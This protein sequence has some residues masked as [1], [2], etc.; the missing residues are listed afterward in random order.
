MDSGKQTRPRRRK[1]KLI[2]ESSHTHDVVQRYTRLVHEV[3]A[4]EK[5]GD[6]HI[7]AVN[8]LLR[9]QFGDFQGLSTPVLGQGLAFQKFDFLAGFA[10][11]GYYQILHTGADHWMTVKLVSDHE[12]EVYDSVF[13]RPNYITLKQISSIAQCKSSTIQ[14]NLNKVQVQRN[15]VDCGVYAIAYL[16]D[17]CHGKDPASCKYAGAVELRDHL[18]SCF[19]NGRM[20]PFPSSDIVK[21]KA[22]I[23]QFQVYCSCRLPRAIDHVK[24]PPPEEAVIMIQCHICDNLYHHSCVG[25]TKEKARRMNA[26]PRNM[27][28]CDYRGCEEAFGDV[29]ESD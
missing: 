17:L 22:L 12:A 11:F 21:E 6:D 20:S 5:L 15:S 8:Q 16:T 19:E 3:K 9:G 4:G 1:R 18:I 14:L 28:F 25:I 13:L 2:N 29:F 27:W 24:N 26:N 23:Q 10:G 7:N